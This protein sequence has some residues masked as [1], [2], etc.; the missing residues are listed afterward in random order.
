MYP[1]PH[2]HP[3]AYDSV[4]QFTICP[5]EQQEQGD[6]RNNEPEWQVEDDLV[7]RRVNFSHN[8]TNLMRIVG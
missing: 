5:A 2:T 6:D 4:L 3:R 1:H 8:Q 7:L